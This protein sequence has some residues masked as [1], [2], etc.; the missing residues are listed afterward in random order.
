VSRVGAAAAS[1][2]GASL[3]ALA[4]VVAV[5]VL[6]TRRLAGTA[7]LEALAAGCAV[8]LAG[9]A[10]GAAPVLLAVA[11]GGVARAHAVAGRAMALRSGGTFAGALAI[12]LGTG[13][14]RTPFLVWVGIAYGA[15][16][17]VETRWTLRWLAVGEPPAKG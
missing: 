2:L 15:L 10:L 3:L 9:A 7:G 11:R 4:V 13:I 16:L 1:W 8:A 17:V 6:P 12:A 14:A 5:G